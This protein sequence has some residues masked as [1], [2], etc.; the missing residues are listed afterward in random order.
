MLLDGTTRCWR[1]SVQGDP[2]LMR[3]AHADDS[4]TLHSVVRSGRWHCRT[5]KQSPQRSRGHL[6]WPLPAALSRPCNASTF[7]K[8]PAVSTLV[9]N[10]RGQR[11]ER[12]FVDAD[13][14][15]VDKIQT[16]R[17][18]SSDKESKLMHYPTQSKGCARLSDDKW[19]GTLKL[20]K[21]CMAEAQKLWLMGSNFYGYVL[22]FAHRI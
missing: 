19:R 18:N 1:L 2:Y 17:V 7:E 10:R 20:C 8:R 13:Y 6:T 12:D 9:G 3:Q 14:P 4:M 21:S 22:I 15:G 16:R 11:H 5:Q